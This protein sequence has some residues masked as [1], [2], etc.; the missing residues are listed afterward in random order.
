[1][2]RARTEDLPGVEVFIGELDALRGPAYDMV[3]MIGVLEYVGGGAGAEPRVAFLREAAARLKRG[4]T[5][6]CAIENQL[7]V[8]YLAGA[9]EDHVGIPFEG[10]DDYPHDA[11]CRTFPRRARGDVPGGGLARTCTTRS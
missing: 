1:M 4:G 3:V 2:A 10:V 5:L 7:G 9:P 6:V 8:K 11:R